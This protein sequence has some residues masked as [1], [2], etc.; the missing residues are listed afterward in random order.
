LQADFR[1]LATRFDSGE[2]VAASLLDVEINDFLVHLFGLTSWPDEDVVWGPELERLVRGNYEDRASAEERLA[3]TSTD[4]ELDPSDALEPGW[5]ADLTTFQKRDIRHL[6]TLHHGANFSVPGAGK[7][8]VALAIFSAMRRLEEVD[9]LLVICPKSAFESW[10]AENVECFQRP[11]QMVRTDGSLSGSTEA[12]LINYER[13]SDAAPTLITW[14]RRGKGLLVLDE[15]HRMKRGTRGVYGRTCMSLGPYAAKRLILTGT[16]VPNSIADLQSLMAFVWPGQGLELVNGAMASGSLSIASQQLRPLFVRTKKS[17]LGL[18]VPVR[19]VRRLPLEGV[20]RKLYDA[21]LGHFQSEVQGH[22]DDDLSR[23]GRVVLYLLMA[24]TSPALLPLGGHRYEPLA[25]QL[26]PLN[27][28]EGSSLQLL[29]ANLPTYEMTPKFVELA[30]VLSR[31][32][33]LGRKTLVWSTFVR[34]LTTLERLLEEYQ[35]AL[36]HGGTV[37]REGELDRFRRDP[38]CWVLLSNPATLGE[39]ISLHQVCK[40]AVYVDRDFAA[41]RFLQSLDR[42]H[43]L[44]LPPD[45]EVRV[46]ILLSERTVD[47]LVEE[48]LRAKLDFMGRILDDPDVQELSDLNEEPTESA[49]L[50]VDDVRLLL[51]HLN[52]P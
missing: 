2:L 7:T 17:E 28:P 42:I 3:G 49:G 50:D 43:R 4:S 27:P 34:T 26:P 30:T 22:A 40:D 44:G 5:M 29:L 39:G 38:D 8:R 23:L 31:N 33:A 9:R 1:V 6:L 37:D 45:A 15:A 19:E 18:P 48:R 35:P 25:Y 12:V 10:E 16:P 32:R 36:V 51:G 52:G 46:T 21:L 13:I 24:A 41:G 20:H 14:L 11:L 47:E